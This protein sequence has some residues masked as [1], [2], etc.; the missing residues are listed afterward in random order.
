MSAHESRNIHSTADANVDFHRLSHCRLAIWVFLRFACTC[1]ID[2]WA[3][4]F[5]E[6]LE[7]LLLSLRRCRSKFAAMNSSVSIESIDVGT[8]S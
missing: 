8:R 6:A 1:C 5:A 7:Q 4:S 2:G 3:A